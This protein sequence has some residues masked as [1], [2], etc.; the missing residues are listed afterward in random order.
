M[1]K[2]LIFL[3]LLCG[4]KATAQHRTYLLN[5]D[6]V[7]VSH[8]LHIGG[9]LIF[10]TAPTKVTGL[11]YVVTRDSVTGIAKILKTT[12]GSSGTVTTASIVTAN[13]ISGSVANPNTTPAITLILQ[14]A[15]T[16]QSGQ[17][18][19]TDW[20]TF[21]NKQSTITFG[22]G[23]QTAVG[24]NIGSA[25][26]PVLFNGAGGTPSSMVGTNISGT[27]ASLNIGGSAGSVGSALTAGYGTSFSSFTGA[28]TRA[29]VIDTA[30]TN[31]IMSKVRGASKAHVDSLFAS[32]TLYF[33]TGI[34]GS[35]TSGS[36]FVVDNTVFAPLVSPSFTTPALGTPSSGNASNLT[37]IP[38]A[39]A[40]GN[41]GV[42]HLNSGT[43]AT[44]S[45]YWRGDGVWATPS[46]AGTVT[47]I[48][49][50]T[51]LS[52]GTITSSG[53]IAVNT[54]QNIATLSNLTSNGIVTT[55]GAAGTLSVTATTGSGNVVLVTSPTLVTPNLGTPGTLNIV[56]ATGMTSGQVTTALGFTP[57]TVLTALNAQTS[58]Y[59]LVLGDAGNTEVQ[60]N[61]ASANNLT[62]PTNASVAFAIGTTITI[63]SIG[64]GQTTIVPTGGVTMNAAGGATKLRVQYSHAVLLKTA[65]NTW[66]LSGDIQ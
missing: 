19:N 43:G 49:A 27:A 34:A 30:S 6:T 40:S 13:G 62:I 64:A 32:T 41:L 7:K 28:V 12:I 63:T 31:G 10:K 29:V 17:L 45:S 8:D 42:T 2:L 57:M 33:G 61:N 11:Q 16:S 20:N 55:S 21:N 46:G 58:S 18:T 65:T 44:S 9:N 52:G 15:T 51:G 59:T 4:L 35:G 23:V 37:N 50:G 5:Y 3:A 48:I 24:V 1:K 53:T 22:T 39:N 36:P 54:S 47:S 14:N 26:A 66:E 38:M 56:N 60:M 25:G